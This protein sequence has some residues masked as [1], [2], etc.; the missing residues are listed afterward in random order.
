MGSP[1][2]GR[3]RSCFARFIDLLIL[4][5]LLDHG[6]KRDDKAHRAYIGCHIELKYPYGQA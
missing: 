5:L 4:K 3:G 2:E 1:G 6:R